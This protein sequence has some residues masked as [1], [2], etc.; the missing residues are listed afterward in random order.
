VHQKV[1]TAG[2]CCVA[3]GSHESP[4]DGSRSGA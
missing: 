4:P 1:T 2:R 3:V